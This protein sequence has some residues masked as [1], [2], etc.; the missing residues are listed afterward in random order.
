MLLRHTIPL[1]GSSLLILSA[2]A[3]TPA[4]PLPSPSSTSTKEKAANTAAETQP[5]KRSLDGS[6]P[7]TMPE[8]EERLLKVLALPP[9]QINKE[10][11]A[12]IFGI[13][14]DGNEHPLFFEEISADKQ[15][16]FSVTTPAYWPSN[17]VFDYKTAVKKISKDNGEEYLEDSPRE[18]PE[19]YKFPYLPF[20][21]KLASFGWQHK[22]LN[23]DVGNH[24]SYFMKD[25]FLLVVHIDNYQYR[26]DS[27]PDY[28]QTRISRIVINAPIK[29]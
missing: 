22:G 17:P 29:R 9:A 21:Q 2:C 20:V 18:I 19:A 23:S 7:F 28:A 6:A 26:A 3:T 1:L 15:T 11:V 5:P 16:I 27:Q 4:A 24:S 14:L 25:G 10:S 13:V 8:I 12:K